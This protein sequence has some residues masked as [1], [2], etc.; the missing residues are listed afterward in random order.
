MDPDTTPSPEGLTEA[1][2]PDLLAAKT[3]RGVQV[4]KQAFL[5]RLIVVP[6]FPISDAAMRQIIKLQL[7]RIATRP[8]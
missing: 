8:R 3:E 4:F 6:Y 7:G 1:V 2:R 5:G